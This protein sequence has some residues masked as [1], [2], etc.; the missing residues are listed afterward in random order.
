MMSGKGIGLYIGAKS[1]SVAQVENRSGRAVLQKL[2]IAETPPDSIDR[3]IVTDAESIAK[4]LKEIWEEEKIEGKRVGLAMP[5]V[6]LI[7]RSMTLPRMS[8]SEVYEALRT[9]VE[10]YA[11]IS[12]AEPVLDWK[13]IP[14]SAQ[15]AFSTFD[16]L[17]AATTAENVLQ[18]L[19][20]LREAGLRTGFVDVLP[21][22]MARS[23][24]SADLLKPD[25]PFN[26]AVAVDTEITTAIAFYHGFPSFAHTIEIG[27][28][29]I[30]EG[31]DE[32]AYELTLC[33]NFYRN[34]YPDE[35]V[36]NLFLALDSSDYE[37]VLKDLRDRTE[38]Q[39]VKVNPLANIDEVECPTEVAESHVLSCSVAIGSA[40]RGAGL[41]P[42][43]AEL[44]LMP[45]SI[46]TRAHLKR[47]ITEIGVLMV[48]ILILG[49]GIGGALDM[50]VN[51]ILKEKAI[52]Q[53]K[54]SQLD[55]QSLKK[56]IE[57]QRKTDEFRDRTARYRKM[58]KSLKISSQHE[59]LN[60]IRSVI[61]KD[62]WLEKISC[63]E[64]G[65]ISL[66]GY[67]FSE[68]SVFLFADMLRLLSAEGQVN[69]SVQRESSLVSFHMELKLKRRG[70]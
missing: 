67:S 7:I 32:L 24:V 49:L 18:Y 45:R 37:K 9:E 28:R 41:G 2:T 8:D 22:A 61:P 66:D 5:A 26:I 42:D 53:Q 31:V 70:R 64:D 29:D 56:V 58:L 35:E 6:N 54:M 25:S 21:L 51:S 69:I 20:L 55:E 4:S 59:L 36:S 30:S 19:S 46:L 10:G 43:V 52:L 17:F 57:L 12:G 68:D 38:E 14:E 15:G 63:D 60:Y 13:I 16:V 34:D 62:S 33:C 47:Q 11:V 27:A 40:L 1:I 23:F 65:K 44:N 50:K 48:G 3:G 39:M